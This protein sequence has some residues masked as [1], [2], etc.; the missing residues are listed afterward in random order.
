MRRAALLAGILALPWPALA[1][2]SPD[3]TARKEIAVDTTA[4]GANTQTTLSDVP[5]LIRLHAG[6]FPQF[7]TVRDN[8]A[9]FRFTAGDDATPLQYH[10]ERF[11]PISQI[12][13][14]WV[15]VPSLVAQSN[16]NKLY[17]YF[18]NEAAA[19]GDD[20]GASYDV[21][22][23]SVFHFS[24]P[25]GQPLDSTSYGTLATGQVVANPASLVGGGALL[26]GAGS[27]SLVDAPHLH[28]GPDMGW[29]FSTWLKLNEFPAATGQPAAY[30]LDRRGA[31]NRLS[32]T[33]NGSQLSATYNDMQVTASTALSQAQ[34]QHVAVVM[35]SAQIRLY[36]DGVEV[37]TWRATPIGSL[38]PPACRGPR[39][40]KSS[41]TGWIRRRRAAPREPSAPAT[42]ASSSRTCS[43]RR[44]PGSSSS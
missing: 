2:W 24:Q 17:F 44:T 20:P 4:A 37:G 18:G 36:L 26:T 10:V 40:I 23:V 15:K 14:V 32:V 31:Q 25:T 42:S 29:T 30:L 13:L 1:W 16:A 3:W 41:S 34:W 11:D 38:S 35:E 5:V 39:T 7:L 12:A 28:S 8:G 43:A 27:L 21:N 33:I 9:D 6:N 19:A 22:T